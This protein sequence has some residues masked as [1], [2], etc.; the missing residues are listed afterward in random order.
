MHSFVYF[1]IILT[2]KIIDQENFVL[3]KGNKIIVNII[4]LK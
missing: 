3:I 2:Y 1:I 4:R